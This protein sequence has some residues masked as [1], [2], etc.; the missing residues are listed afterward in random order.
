[1]DISEISKYQ[2]QKNK[3]NNI[4]KEKL[5][6]LNA[7]IQKIIDFAIAIFIRILVFLL[8][9][10]LL[11]YTLPKESLNAIKNAT[12]P[13]QKF[14][15]IYQLDSLNTILSQ[16]LIIGFISGIFYYVLMVSRSSFGTIGM[17]L[18]RIQIVNKNGERPT[19]L[20]AIIW[21][22]L[23]IIYP[24]CAILALLRL[25]NNKI[26][27]ILIILSILTLLFSEIPRTIFG[28]PSMAEK[29]SGLHLC[30]KSKS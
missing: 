21:Y 23:T 1:M 29:I 8:S 27:G 12:T 19:I 11:L 18:T 13:E 28:L 5:P 24:V 4:S 7:M 9:Y 26:D 20:Q 16:S 22:H 2:F 30:I 14:A 25:Y 10:K 15:L 17:K 3:K 6:I